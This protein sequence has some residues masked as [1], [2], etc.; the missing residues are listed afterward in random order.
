MAN[1]KGRRASIKRAAKEFQQNANSIVS[2]AEAAT[3]NLTKGH[4]AWAHDYAVI[5]LYREFESLMLEALVGAINNDPSTISATTGVAFPRHVTKPV[6]EFL[7][8]GNGYFDFKGRSG[9]IKLVKD[10]VPDTHYLVKVLKNKA[11][12]APLDQLSALRNFAAHNSAQSKQAAINATGMKNLGSSGNWL[13]VNNRL[14]Q[15]RD[16]L[17]TLAADIEANA[18]Y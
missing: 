16:E 5:R 8:T 4:S 12:T 2:F 17:N 13:R 14:G 15:L 10:Y 11:Y 3:D 7:V 9:L 1:G 6:A 18:P